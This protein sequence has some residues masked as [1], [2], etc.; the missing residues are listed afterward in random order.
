MPDIPTY[1]DDAA[2]GTG[3]QQITIA[4]FPFVWAAAPIEKTVT[5]NGTNQVDMEFKPP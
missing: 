3:A 2:A 5:L 4:Y 1:A